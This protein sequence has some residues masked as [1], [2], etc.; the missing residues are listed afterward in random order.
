[1]NCFLVC[2]ITSRLAKTSNFRIIHYIDF[3]VSG[4]V[5]KVNIKLDT[6]FDAMSDTDRWVC[7]FSSWS[8][9]QSNS[10]KV[11]TAVRIYVSSSRKW[12]ERFY[13]SCILL[14][15]A[16]T[17]SNNCCF[18]GFDQATIIL[19]GMF[20]R[21]VVTS[22][23]G[24]RSCRFLFV[25]ER[26]NRNIYTTRNNN[27]QYPNILIYAVHNENLF[28][29]NWTIR[30][31]IMWYLRNVCY[32]YK[33]HILQTAGIYIF[34]QCI[35]VGENTLERLELGYKTREMETKAKILFEFENFYKKLNSNVVWNIFMM[36]VP[37]YT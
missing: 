18:N 28:L 1:M 16:R 30:Y 2:S 10:S 27:I 23:D 15:I 13:I 37:K 7:M 5:W 20:D 17:F 36:W 25:R 32:F 26:K 21:G 22:F 34:L 11:S 31:T 19:P 8:K 3:E 33:V 24:V 12:N 35:M 29:N 9:H 6:L 4:R 14:Q